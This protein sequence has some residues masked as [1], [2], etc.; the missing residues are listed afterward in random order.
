MKVQGSGF[1]VPGSGCRVQGLKVKVWVQGSYASSQ[2]V[3][4]FGWGVIFEGSGCSG[5]ESRKSVQSF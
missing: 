2:R 5:L 3:M 4:C 1:R